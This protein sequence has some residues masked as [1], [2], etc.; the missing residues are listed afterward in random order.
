M[1]RHAINLFTHCPINDLLLPQGDIAPF[2]P[3][4]QVDCP[5]WLAINLKQRQKCRLIPPAWMNVGTCCSRISRRS[6][7][8]F[9]LDILRYATVSVVSASVTTFCNIEGNKLAFIMIYDEQST[10]YIN[11]IT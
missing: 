2:N 4:L 1:C 6:G 3:G 5:L 10:L 7:P 8:V 9:L 11:Y